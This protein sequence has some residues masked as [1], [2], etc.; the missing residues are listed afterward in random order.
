MAGIDFFGRSPSNKYVHECVKMSDS[1]NE[2]QTPW[3]LLVLYEREDLASAFL[4][5]LAHLSESL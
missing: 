5:R 1:K 2:C 4:K 3:K